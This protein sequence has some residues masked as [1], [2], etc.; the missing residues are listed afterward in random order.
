M[1]IW[2]LRLHSSPERVNVTS[3]TLLIPSTM[4]SVCLVSVLK[5][6]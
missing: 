6:L 5:R 1:F 3:F 4:T 2:M